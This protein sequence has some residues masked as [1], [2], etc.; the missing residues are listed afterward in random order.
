MLTLPTAEAKRPHAGTACSAGCSRCPPLLCKPRMLRART[1]LRAPP[2]ALLLPLQFRTQHQCSA[3]Q[4]GLPNRRWEQQDF[5]LERQ[6]IARTCA[7]TASKAI[8]TSSSRKSSPWDWE[9]TA[10]HDQKTK[11]RQNRGL[12]WE[13]KHHFTH[14]RVTVAP[15]ALGLLHASQQCTAQDYFPITPKF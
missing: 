12:G 8:N 15:P 13:V 7:S 3:G 11:K 6:R 10:E 2:L 4:L 9:T 14:I 1:D 5:S